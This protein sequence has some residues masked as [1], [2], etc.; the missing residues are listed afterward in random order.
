MKQQDWTEQLRQRLAEHESHVPEG[1]W[2]DIERRM[3][4]RARRVII[5]R[6][7]AAAAACALLLVGSWQ[8]LKQQQEPQ[9][10]Q[11]QLSATNSLTVQ[12]DDTR[13]EKV[14]E[15]AQ[16]TQA[17]TPAQDAHSTQKAH[18]AQIAHLAQNA[19]D[20]HPAQD[21]HPA[22][23]IQDTHPAQDTLPTIPSQPTERNPLRRDQ[24]IP[25]K[26]Q[27][28]RRQAIRPS[29]Q[30]HTTNLLAQGSM[31]QTEPMLMTRSYMG[32]TSQSLARQTPVYLS[33]HEEKTEH[34]MPF[35]IGLSL[36]IPMNDRWW[37]ATG[38][39][40][41]RVS[42]TFTYTSNISQQ[43]NEQRLYYLSLP[44]TAGYT[45][46]QSPRLTAYI[47]AGAEAHYN[48]CT[49]L[50]NGHLARDRMQFSFTGSAG[51]E[52]RLLKHTSIFVQP[53]L[54]Y[55]PDNGSHIKNIFKERPWMLDL[56]FGLRYSL[57]D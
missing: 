42:S 25:I 13:I 39:N 7:I 53:G 26:R 29:L 44:A 35:T 11:Q 49:K 36:R 10:S 30:L 3:N 32:P 46:W 27:T 17:P 34:H 20:D 50:D 24:R 9:Q 54:R 15:E 19:Q 51:L 37:V 6:W 1:L 38:V 4:K 57:K 12:P 14:D 18:P 48:I 21:S 56:Q 8:L 28:E 31:T 2:D 45:F 33:N 23:D 16:P 5:R 55:Y 52:Y 41:S 47:S 43:V 22:Q 40:Y